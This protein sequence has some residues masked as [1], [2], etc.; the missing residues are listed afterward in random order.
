VWAIGSLEDPAAL[1]ILGAATSDRSPRVR[2]TAAWAIGQIEDEGAKAPPG[3]LHLLSDTDAD[4][5]LKA[6]WAL[7]QLRDASALPALRDAMRD[8]QNDRVRRALIRGMMKSGD[9]SETTMTQLLN[10]SDPR[11]RE[12]AVRGLAGRNAFDPWPWPWP[13]PRP[14]P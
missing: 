13:R 6:A 3:L 5:R 12:A 14:F 11:I 4:I 7:G 2:G 8:E 9:R 1:D 10:S